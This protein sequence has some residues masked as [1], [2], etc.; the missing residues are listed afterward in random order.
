M[1]RIRVI[2]PE[3]RA[4]M[5]QGGLTRAKQFTPEY[6]RQ[7]R[8]RL[9]R[10]ACVKGGKAAYKKLVESKGLEYAQDKAADWRRA[11]EGTSL[12]RKVMPHLPA[13]YKFEAK[14]KQGD[15]FYYV[16]FLIGNIIVEVNGE[17]VHQKRQESDAKKYKT[18]ATWGYT[19]IILPERD[20]ESGEAQKLLDK[21]FTEEKGLS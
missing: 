16:D 20:I 21:L 9:P 4:K 6:Q 11:K 14:I 3:S 17:W 1:N 15:V 5:R 13:G 10:E 8:S 19:V 2:S 7:T 18:L 12:E